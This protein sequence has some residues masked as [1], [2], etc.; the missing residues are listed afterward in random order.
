MAFDKQD[1][2]D[3]FQRILGRDPRQS[4]IDDFMRF[5]STGGVDL[6]AEDVGKIIG[7]TREARESD[8]RR[9]GREFGTE[10]A[11]SDENILQQAESQL[12]SRLAQQGR[13]ISGSPFVNAFANASRDLA[14]ARQN[15]IAGFLGSGFQDIN[16]GAFT[17]AQQRQAFG[18][19]Q[20]SL[21]REQQFA[22]QSQVLGRDIQEGQL[23]AL[24]RQSNLKA[25]LGLGLGA[26]G[27]GLG[28]MGGLAG[29]RFGFQ[30][31][32]QVG[33]ALGTIGGS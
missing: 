7:G 12:R 20:Q 28:S 14:Q 21:A 18:Q 13:N 10:L 15:T 22:M 26:I 31:G 23:N 25:G 19:G 27:A 3:Q 9:T 32:S 16:R 11:R 1:I 2:R 4:E 8:L 17:Q 24:K 29:A 6:S 33:S 30:A 5:A